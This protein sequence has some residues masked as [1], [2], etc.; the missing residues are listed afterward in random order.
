MPDKLNGIIFSEILADNAGGSALDTDGDGNTNKSDEFI[1]LQNTTGSAVSLDGYA[2]WS[3]KGGLLYSFDS[4]DTIDPG[5]T[6]TVVGNYSGVT[7]PSSFYDAGISE[8]TNWLPDGEGQKFETIYLVDTSNGDYV[9]IS[10]GNPPRPPA[11]PNGFP[12]TTQIGAGENVD[13]NFPNGTVILRDGN[14]DFIEGSPTPGTPGVPCFVAG[15]MIATADGLTPIEDIRPGQ[16]V[17]TLD[18]ALVPV[19]AIRTV[20]VTPFMQLRCPQICP[21]TFPA[22]AIGNQQALTVSPAHR[23]LL[24]GSAVQLLAGTFEAFA[25]A[26]QCIG[27]RSVTQ[28]RPGAE[29]TYVH[30]LFEDHQIVQANGIWTESLFLGDLIAPI[31]TE[32]A[33]WRVDPTVVLDRISHPGLARQM[34]NRH[35]TA[36]AL[37]RFGHSVQQSDAVA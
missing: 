11:P 20:R 30:L 14:G 34:L 8:G 37:T 7:V 10:Y 18:D 21:V 23:I 3:D 32:A 15:T 25:A 16:Q 33:G 12:G 36:L 27:L 28:A 9:R 35:E 29:L 17:K 22:G 13:T 26:A 2:L 24:G 31:L 5:G 1:E 6:A 19:R 4:G